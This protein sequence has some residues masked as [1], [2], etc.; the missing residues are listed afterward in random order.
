MKALKINKKRYIHISLVGNY[1]NESYQQVCILTCPH[2]CRHTHTP[3]R[4]TLTHEWVRDLTHRHEIMTRSAC[5]SAFNYNISYRNMIMNLGPTHEDCNN[6]GKK[7][8]AH[9]DHQFNKTP[10]QSPINTCK[11][12]KKIT[13]W[14]DP[15][16]THQC[17]GNR[18]YRV[19]SA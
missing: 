13:S 11:E 14:G 19:T 1:G 15:L 3:M 9:L 2:T 6:S 7:Q 16:T 8:H 12:I 5:R 10:N 18:R 4:S 17:G